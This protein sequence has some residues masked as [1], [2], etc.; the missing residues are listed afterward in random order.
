[1]R[2]RRDLSK[3]RAIAARSLLG[4]FAAISA[5]GSDAAAGVLS[6]S[7]G[8]VTAQTLRLPD[9]PGSVRGFADPASVSVFSGQVVYSVPLSLPAG[10]AGF[11]PRLS[12]NYSGDLGN[13]AF[14]VGWALQLPVIRRRLHEGVPR[15]SDQ[16][17][18]ELV[19]VG[20]GGRLF[21]CDGKRYWVEGRGTSIKVDRRGRWWEP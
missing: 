10:R 17:E 5:L 8:S 20:N 6:P 18:L 12:L 9:K 19:G 21:S 7:P 4:L 13:S 16:D 2:P 11:G 3:G 15:Y 14:G 1:M